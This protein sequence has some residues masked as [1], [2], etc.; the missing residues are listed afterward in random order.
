M[1]YSLRG[2]ANEML[3]VSLDYESRYLGKKVI[4]LIAGKFGKSAMAVALSLVMVIYG[5]RHETM[6]YLM[7]TALVFTL[8]W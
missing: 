7:A 4:S 6:W 3:Y 5:D 1:E 8:L 2:A